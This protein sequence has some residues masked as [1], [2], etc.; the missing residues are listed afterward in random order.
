VG[1]DPRDIH[2][3]S[4]AR[5][6]EPVI[7]EYERDGA[8]TRWICLDTRSEPTE[9]AEVAVEVAA[10]LAARAIRE[11]RP[12]ALVVGDVVIEP[13]EGPGQLERILDLLARVDFS[14]SNRAPAPPLDPASCILVCVEGG[15][16]YG[17]VLAVG[18]DATLDI[19]EAA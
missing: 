11:T 18:T 8:E 17:D 7:R 5:L 10:S 12:V 3:R 13:G 4:S 6:R 14:P 19:E 9:A 16:G 15:S 2:W 1:D